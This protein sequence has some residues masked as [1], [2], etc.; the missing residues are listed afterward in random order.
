MDSIITGDESWCFVY[1]PETQCQIG[2]WFQ[3]MT[4]VLDVS[5]LQITVYC[6]IWTNRLEIWYIPKGGVEKWVPK[7][8]WRW[9]HQYQFRKRRLKTYG[10][11]CVGVCVQKLILKLFFRKIVK[12]AQEPQ[13]KIFNQKSWKLKNL[14]FK[15]WNYYQG[16]ILRF[17]YLK[18]NDIFRNIRETFGSREIQ[19]WFRIFKNQQVAQVDVS[20]EVLWYCWVDWYIGY[21]RIFRIEETNF[22][23]KSQNS[24]LA[25]KYVKPYPSQVTN[26]IDTSLLLCYL[27]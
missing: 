8:S 2:S 27:Q 22:E 20:A 19:I 4:Q 5:W 11:H 1:D 7:I 12:Y 6:R 25:S 26:F 17:R 10:T 9:G 21:A 14:Q 24:K 3:I 16:G 18:I 13:N 15:I 23:L